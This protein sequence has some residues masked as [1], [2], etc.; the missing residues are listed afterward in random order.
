M[1][2]V[3]EIKNKRKYLYLNQLCKDISDYNLTYFFRVYDTT[4]NEIIIFHKE[5]STLYYSNIIY[6]Y[7]HNKYSMRLVE[8]NQLVKE[9]FEENIGCFKVIN[10]ELM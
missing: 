1:N 2:L 8:V 9:Y 6:A 7:Y 3:K 10:V 5:T 4:N